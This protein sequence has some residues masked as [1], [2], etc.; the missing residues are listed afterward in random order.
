M[1]PDDIQLVRDEEGRLHVFIESDV[2]FH[3]M[4]DKQEIVSG[5]SLDYSNQKFV[6]TT[7]GHHTN[8]PFNNELEDIINN[9][10]ISNAIKNKTQ[11]FY[12]QPGR[13]DYKT[14]GKQNMFNRNLRFGN[15]CGCK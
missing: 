7:H 6:A 2:V 3:F 1:L 5:N 4:G 15:K 13:L 9:P 12:K 10:V 11:K 14:I 8:P